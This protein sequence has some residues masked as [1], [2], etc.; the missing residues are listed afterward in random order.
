[1]IFKIGVDVGGTFTDF[2]LMD[3]EGNSDIFKVLSSPED[4]SIAVMNGLN[5][6]AGTK[7]IS[8]RSFLGKIE[9]IVHGTTVTTNAVLTGNV[10]KTGLLTTKGFRDALQ[11][12][13][14]IREELYNN[15]YLQ[16][17]PI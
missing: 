7:G 4:P 6:M 12:R 2:L 13:R 15:K 16:P 3:N 9:I 17:A 14:G 5:Q 1:M 10:S 11:M 8:L